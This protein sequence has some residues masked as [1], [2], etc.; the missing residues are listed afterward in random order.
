MG[1]CG[2]DGVAVDQGSNDA[3]IEDVA[4]TCSV[5]RGRLEDAQGLVAS[6]DA[7]D[8]QPDRVP[9][10]AP[11]AEILRDLVLER[12]SGDRGRHLWGLK[13]GGCCHRRAPLEI[14][15]LLRCATIPG[16]VTACSV[17]RQHPRVLTKPE[18]FL[19][20]FRT[21]CWRH[22]LYR[23]NSDGSSSMGS[24]SQRAYS[25]DSCHRFCQLVDSTS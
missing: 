7:A 16:H 20:H 15:G 10:P 25:G 17:R 5:I 1:D 2:A 21:M 9:R 8:T 14:A 3:A 6:P 24:R 18:P 23:L 19:D 12:V 11:V 22:L 4:R 13:G